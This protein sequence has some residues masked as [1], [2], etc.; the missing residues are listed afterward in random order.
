MCL[1]GTCHGLVRLPHGFLAGALTQDIQHDG[2][3][4]REAA[5]AQWPAK[6][7]PEMLL[8]LRRSASLQHKTVQ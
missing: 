4:N 5:I 7:C 6:H 2:G 3:A 8:V 1:E